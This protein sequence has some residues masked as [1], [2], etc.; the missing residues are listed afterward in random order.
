[1]PASDESSVEC[2]ARR[3]PTEMPWVMCVWDFFVSVG[4]SLMGARDADRLYFSASEQE[5]NGNRVG[6]TELDVEDV[7]K[8]NRK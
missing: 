2:I 7:R 5:E 3:V 4:S 8:R 6:G 1:M